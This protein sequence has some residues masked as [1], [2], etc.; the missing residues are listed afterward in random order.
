MG[1]GGNGGNHQDSLNSS[2]LIKN[3]GIGGI[4]VCMYEGGKI[5]P[6]T[7]RPN[8]CVCVSVC[9]CECV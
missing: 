5:D 2:P 8:V 7:E 6:K 3:W 1:E 9:E 4:C